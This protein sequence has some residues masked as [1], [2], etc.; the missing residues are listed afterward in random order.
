MW[1]CVSVG[2]KGRLVRFAAGFGVPAAVHQ[3]VAGYLDVDFAGLCRVN[4]LYEFGGGAGPEFVGADFGV[5]EYDGTGGDDGAFAY[6]GVVHHHGTHADE[7][8]V[9]DV[10]AMDG[11]IVADGDV[12]AYPAYRFF[13]KGMQ[14][15]AV[16]D[17]DA[18]ADGDGVDVAA[19]GYAEPYRALVA[20]GY[21]ADYCCRFGQKAA[22]AE[23]GG[24]SP[25]WNYCCHFF[26]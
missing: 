4:H 3:V 17:V 19:Q 9:V 16:L 10:G 25:Q 2:E 26:D 14:H 8:Q 23:F 13:V 24:V 22:V 6:D 15:C 7:G 5:F 1:C 21:V 12:I 11:D 18:V 20:H